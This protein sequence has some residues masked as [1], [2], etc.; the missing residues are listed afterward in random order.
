MVDKS[1]LPSTGIITPQLAKLSAMTLI[2]L[3][4]G[5]LEMVFDASNAILRHAR[6]GGCEVVRGVFAAVRDRNW[7]TVVPQVQELVVDQSADGFSAQFRVVCRER[8]IDFT[9]K[10]EITGAADGTVRFEFDGVAGSSFWKNRIGLCVLH[11]IAE[12]AGAPCTVEQ[13]DG[14]VFEGAFPQFISPHQPFKNIRA[15]T[16]EVM[17]GLR[18]TVRMEGE[19]FEMEDQRNW[20]DAS[21]KT[22]STPLEDPFPVLVEAG[23]RVQH[24]V[25]I[26]LDGTVTESAEKDRPHLCIAWDKPVLRPS[27]GLGMATHGGKLSLPG[28]AALQKM[29]PSHL[30]VDVDMRREDWRVYLQDAVDLSRTVGAKIEIAATLSDDADREL[31]MLLSVVR[32]HQEEIG[33]WMVFHAAEKVTSPR[34]VTL[35]QG[36]LAALGDSTPVAAGTNAYFAELNRNRPDTTSPALACFSLNPQV[37]AFDDLSLVETLEAQRATVECARQFGAKPVVISPITL[38][39]RFNPNATD[40]TTP[41]EPESDPRQASDFAAAWMLGSLG[42]LLPWGHV[43]SLTYFETHG[44]RGVMADD[45]TRYPVAK[46]F[47]ALQGFDL[48]CDAPSSHPLMFQA[49]ALQNQQG[50]HRLLVASFAE[51]AQSIAANAPNGTGIVIELPAGGIVS[52]D[53]K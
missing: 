48:V 43:H 21:F 41:S 39:P 12:C 16:H 38:R 2:P 34:W 37:H 18:A 42:R 24:V 32:E 46:V 28:V 33:L 14:V 25:T 50:A 45:G 11:P 13:T 9:W 4:A 47:S 17:P 8:E 52:L 20:T 53:L 22:Y 51:T 6:M 35:M 44:P 19:A 26:S 29:S 49:V 3:R 27:V 5:P 1:M 7:G 10:G 15:I 30:R 31:D 36:K 40:N 23:V